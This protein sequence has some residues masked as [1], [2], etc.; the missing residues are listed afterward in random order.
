M[1]LKTAHLGKEREGLA[2]S[3]CGFA[4]EMLTLPSSRFVGTRWVPRHPALHP[5]RGA[6]LGG[7]S[8]EVYVELTG[9]ISGYPSGG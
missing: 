2:P 9:A 8:F 4:C 3:F 6:S 5:Q 1:H 7:K